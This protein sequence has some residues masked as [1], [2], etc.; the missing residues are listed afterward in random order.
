[1]STSVLRYLTGTV[2]I[3]LWVGML[4]VTVQT[5]TEGVHYKPKSL[6]E[7]RGVLINPG[8]THREEVIR[9]DPDDGEI[10]IL[11]GQDKNYA[12]Q[13]YMVSSL[14]FFARLEQLY[15][16]MLTGRSQRGFRWLYRPFLM[17]ITSFSCTI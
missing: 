17:H 10:L 7:H 2:A 15:T 8:Q 6:Q 16:C 13:P 5:H 4:V 1:M 12:L 9:N 11:E 14:A 3:V